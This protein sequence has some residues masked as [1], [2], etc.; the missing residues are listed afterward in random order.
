MLK[1]NT[2][3]V[4]RTLKIMASEL[5]STGSLRGKPIKVR[6]EKAGRNVEMNKQEATLLQKAIE[7]AAV[8]HQKQKRKG[9]GR[10]YI[11]HPLS[12]MNKLNKAK[13]DSSNPGLL[14]CAALL[15]DVVEDCG[16]PLDVIAQIFGFQVAGIVEELTLEKDKY[17]TIG[18]T[19]YLC[20]ELT[21]MSSY[22][23]AIKLCDRWDN[24]E[25]MKTMDKNFQK[26]YIEETTTIL[27]YLKANRVKLTN[28]HQALIREIEK[29]M[30]TYDKPTT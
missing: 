14:A 27:S 29:E 6:V 11:V 4:L 7:F 5:I 2:Q 15:H 26:T 19:K 13:P 10:P 22:A 8:A 17:F 21:K 23:L 28:T 3:V 16:I 24:I 20:E 9:D 25:D 12:V 30:L 18:K 1:G